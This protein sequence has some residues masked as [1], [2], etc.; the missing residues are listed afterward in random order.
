MR[1]IEEPAMK[2]LYSAVLFVALCRAG[3][4]TS[5]VVV[6][7]GSQACNTPCSLS[8]TNG[9]A[10]ASAG[11]LSVETSASQG[12]AP[13]GSESPFASVSLLDEESELFTDGSGTGIANVSFRY[14]LGG[15]RG[16]N[17]IGVQFG[18]ASTTIQDGSAL[19]NL[20]TPFTYGVPFLLSFDF[21]AQSSAVELD[22]AESTYAD[23]EDIVVTD[24]V[25]APEASALWLSSLGLAAT[26]LWWVFRRR[27]TE[28][29]RSQLARRI[30][31]N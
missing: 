5:T 27:R 15:V 8:D 18:D 25:A 19:V 12:F 28:R 30:L 14:F 20:T 4:I 26:T 11:F 10:S 16:N 24:P 3:V 29:R 23:I 21:E 6:Q 31:I 17:T 7:L 1:A 13:A 2:T 9:A 22:E